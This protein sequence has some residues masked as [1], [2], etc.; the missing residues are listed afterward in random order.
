MKKTLALVLIAL[1]AMTMVFADNTP[2][3]SSKSLTLVQTV[4]ETGE[5]D[6]GSGEVVALSSL[7]KIYEDPT[8]GTEVTDNEKYEVEIATTDGLAT[9]KDFYFGY[10]GNRKTGPSYTITMT[11]PGFYNS[12]VYGDFTTAKAA[13][14][15]TQIY[16]L[17][18]AVEFAGTE[19]TESVARWISSATN[20]TTGAENLV[21][22]IADHKN[23][24]DVTNVGSVALKW[25]QNTALVAGDYK[26]EV[27]VNITANN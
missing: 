7:L 23:L 11:T 12:T 10:Q 24:K 2:D 25:N 17:D 14:T 3:N 9:E 5:V 19:D 1:M 6:P 22:K 15:A 16:T 18:V 26:A 8:V 4:A 13:N 21:V 20:T 27:S